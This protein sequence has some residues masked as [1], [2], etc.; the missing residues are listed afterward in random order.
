MNLLYFMKKYT[1]V[2]AIILIPLLHGCTTPPEPL[3]NPPQ[4]DIKPSTP[5]RI[6][7]SEQIYYVGT[8][9]Y[10]DKIKSFS[11]DDKAAYQLS[12]GY[13]SKEGCFKDVKDKMNIFDNSYKHYIIIGN[14]YVFTKKERIT[15]N[16]GIPR[17]GIYFNG[18]TAAIEEKEIE[19]YIPLKNITK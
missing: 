9:E 15:P 2:A 13:Y 18:E 16:K 19:G 8:P 5:S 10:K 4:K 1:H 14:W 6:Q 7:K 3:S 12:R 11:F 17:S